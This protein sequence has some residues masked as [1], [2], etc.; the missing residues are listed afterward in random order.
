MSDHPL[1]IVVITE[2]VPRLASRLADACP[3]VKV[4]AAATAADVLRKAG[5][6]RAVMGLAQTITQELVAAAPRLEWVQSFTTGVDPLMSLTLPERVIVT[7]AR[8]IHGPQMSEMA[9]MHMLALAR[10]LPRI[11]KNQQRARWERW[12]QRLLLGKTA[13]IVGLGA[14]SEDLASRCKAFG[15]RVVGV[16]DA[17]GS[18]PGFDRVCPRRELV[19]C[20]RE[21]D[22]MI[23]LAAYSADT[24]HL[25]G[26]EALEALGPQAF[27]INL[28]R[29]AVVDEAALVSRLEKGGFA[30]AGLDVFVEEPL[31]RNSRLW[32]LDN[33]LI[34]PHLGGMSD[35][36][37]EQLFP[38]VVHN[39]QAFA[40]GELGGMRN[41]ITLHPSGART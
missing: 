38:L 30:G 12:P 24:H 40:A 35:C 10:R 22:F 23:V 20:A 26:P 1:E 36:Y 2:D 15:M 34:T 5:S 33:V 9:F 31:P 21:A 14:I 3:N 6:A 39:L 37:E 29:G 16:S 19:G 25:V 32:H 18:A 41:L 17:L 28:A 11:V 8:G 7:S 4:H 27:L 13:V